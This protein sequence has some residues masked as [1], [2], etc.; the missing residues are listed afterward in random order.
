M[1][2]ESLYEIYH[3]WPDYLTACDAVTRAIIDF[4]VVQSPCVRNVRR[5]LIVANQFL[6]EGEF[7]SLAA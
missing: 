7:S 2:S 6:G 4:L 1:S 3:T 5:D